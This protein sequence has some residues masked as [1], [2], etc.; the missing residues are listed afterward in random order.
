MITLKG[1]EKAVVGLVI[2]LIGVV[3]GAL[4]NFT[5]LPADVVPVLNLILGLSTS[6]GTAL[7]VFST[8]NTVLPVGDHEA[9]DDDTTPTPTT[10][11]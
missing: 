4:I 7:G 6:V 3:I 8:T 2:T 11:A 10:T 9:T 1:K 5:G